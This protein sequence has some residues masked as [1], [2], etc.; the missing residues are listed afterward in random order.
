[1]SWMKR[2][3]TLLIRIGGGMLVLLGVLMVTRRLERAVDPAP[4]LDGQLRGS[5]LM[6]LPMRQDVP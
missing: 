6:A 1:M 5:V 3:Y 4:N 2:H